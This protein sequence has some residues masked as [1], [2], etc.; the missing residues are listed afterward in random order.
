MASLTSRPVRALPDSR[1]SQRFGGPALAAWWVHGL[2]E[3]KSSLPR[4]STHATANLHS[5]LVSE[6]VGP[7][8]FTG[9]INHYRLPLR[10]AARSDRG[11]LW[12]TT[13]PCARSV[14][15]RR[16]IRLDP[17]EESTWT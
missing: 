1:L 2:E 14:M 11:E 5:A 9:S 13:A 4:T 3:V 12:V 10:R 15:D 16:L 7:I 6:C 17:T 8:G